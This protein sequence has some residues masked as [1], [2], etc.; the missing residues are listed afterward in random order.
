M[1]AATAWAEETDEYEEYAIA[2]YGEKIEVTVW[3]EGEPDKPKRLKVGGEFVAEYY[4]EE[5]TKP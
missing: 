1:D 5:V 3:K 2:F 4:A